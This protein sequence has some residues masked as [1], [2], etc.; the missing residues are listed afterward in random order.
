MAS[1][2]TRGST[3]PCLLMKSRLPASWIAI[4]CACRDRMR[5][6]PFQWAFS[7]TAAAA[8]FI[9]AGSIGYSFDRQV[10]HYWGHWTQ[11]PVLSEIALGVA[12][13]IVAAVSWRRALRS[14]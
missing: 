12:C 5:K 2:G 6:N 13:A 9:V 7:F 8:L 4:G 10:G 14:S 11:A 3:P 1:R